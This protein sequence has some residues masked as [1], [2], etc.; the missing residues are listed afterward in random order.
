LIV[1][2]TEVHLRQDVGVEFS[3]IVQTREEISPYEKVDASSHQG[4]ACHTKIMQRFCI[5]QHFFF[6]NLY[7]KTGLISI[8]LLFYHDN[9]A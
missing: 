5:M 8:N 9:M 7:G 1:T 6:D 4:V 3:R 2:S